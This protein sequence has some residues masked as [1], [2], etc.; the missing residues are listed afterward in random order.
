MQKVAFYKLKGHLLQN[1]CLLYVQQGISWLFLIG[2]LPHHFM[3]LTASAKGAL[4]GGT[5][6]GTT[7]GSRLSVFIAAFI[8]F[9]VA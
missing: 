3:R 5:D 6:G 2:V 7:S 9:F 1:G 8:S 4:R